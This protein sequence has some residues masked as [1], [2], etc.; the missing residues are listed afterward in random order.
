MLIIKV[1]VEKNRNRII[2]EVHVA[3]EL[4]NKYL[5]NVISSGTLLICGFVKYFLNGVTAQICPRPPY[6]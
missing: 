5:Y 6:C 3:H 4:L 1:S 2:Q